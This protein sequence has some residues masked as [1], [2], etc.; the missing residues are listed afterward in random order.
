[1][2]GREEVG[3]DAHHLWAHDVIIYGSRREVMQ[4]ENLNFGGLILYLKELWAIISPSSAPSS[5]CTPF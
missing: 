5:L 4:R 2:S 1:M 3:A